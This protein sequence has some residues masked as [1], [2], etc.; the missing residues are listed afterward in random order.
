MGCPIDATSGI[1]EQR[2]FHI[3]YK[4]TIFTFVN[5]QVNMICIKGDGQVSAVKTNIFAIWGQHMKIAFQ[6]YISFGGRDVL[7]ANNF[8][9]GTVCNAVFTVEI[10]FSDHSAHCLVAAGFAGPQKSNCAA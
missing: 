3:Y 8:L 1:F 7:S 6:G 9:P 5:S 10:N 2:I 4:G